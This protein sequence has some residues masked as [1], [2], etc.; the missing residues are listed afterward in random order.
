MLSDIKVP[1]DHRGITLTMDFS[2]ST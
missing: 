2:S 1:V